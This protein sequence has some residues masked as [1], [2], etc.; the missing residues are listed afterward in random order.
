MRKVVK[1]QTVNEDNK[2]IQVWMQ[3]LINR[4]LL[5]QLNLP[6]PLAAKVTYQLSKP[7]QRKEDDE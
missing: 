6:I 1:L 4:I 5:E 2:A 3:H 7:L